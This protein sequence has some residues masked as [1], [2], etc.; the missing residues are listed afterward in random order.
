[1]PASFALSAEN[2]KVVLKELRELDPNLRKEM[3]RELK[4][5]LEPLK[6]RLSPSI[7]PESPLS[8]FTG[9]KAKVP[10][11]WN[12]P[13]GSVVTPLGKR[14]RKAGF[15]P[16]AAVRF[17]SSGRNAG[18]EIL[19]LARRARTPQGAGMLRALNASNPVIG[20]LG[21]FVIPAFRRSDNDVQQAAIKV[22]EKFAAKINRRL[23]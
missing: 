16:V 21:R 17:R 11:R 4:S 22:L 15:Y 8:G 9:R 10:F 18:F 20:G 5:A 19:E 14:G 12:K 23:K 7:P 13:R 6:N 1:M 2:L 3:Q